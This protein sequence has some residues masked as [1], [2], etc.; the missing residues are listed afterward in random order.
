MSYRSFGGRVSRGPQRAYHAS[1]QKR[2]GNRSNKEYIDPARFIKAARPVEAEAYT[3]KHMFEDFEV[4]QL[5]HNN[6]AAKGF[7][8]PSPIQDQ[9]IPAG[10]TGQDI[11]GIANTGTGKT[12]AFAVPVL[13]KL[14]T[15][16]NAKALIM[17]PTRELATQ[18]ED[19]CRMIAKGSG[20]FGALL[21]GGAAMGPQ[22]G[23]LR[24]SPTLVIGTP[25]RI[26]DHMERGSLDLAGFNI[27]VLDEVDRMLDMGFIN[28]MRIILGAMAGERQSFFFSATMDP[29][30]RNLIYAESNDPTTISVKTGETTDNVQQDIVQVRRRE[31]KI[32]QLHDL[33]TNTEGMKALVFD[34]TQRSVEKLSIELAA[35]GFK[36]DVIHGGKSQSQRQRA[37]N[38]FKKNDVTILVATD[39]AARG[40]DVSDITHVI[41]YSTPQ[42]YDDYVHR[43]GRAGRAGRTGYALTFIE[44]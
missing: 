39:V 20:L 33:L 35:R 30:V 13:H 14:M 36:A 11:I 40:I 15:D 37:L 28:D 44:S 25:G 38:R 17:A 29:K 9:A 22:L 8:A 6:I 41:N 12:V 26:K 23:D 42:T 16:P 27:V 4:E 43:I 31:E 2:R 24:H 19:E 1:P 32:E 18:I 21:I 10:L 7:T 34:E 5:I 3:P